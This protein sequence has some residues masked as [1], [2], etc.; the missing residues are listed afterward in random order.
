MNRE[1]DRLPAVPITTSEIKQD[2]LFD[3][4]RRGTYQKPEVDKIDNPIGVSTLS[5][6]K[7]TTEEFGDSLDFEDSP[8]SVGED[9]EDAVLDAIG[10]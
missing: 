8:K 3:R 10:E 1:V 4:H 2:E 9:F 7:E 6:S 5:T